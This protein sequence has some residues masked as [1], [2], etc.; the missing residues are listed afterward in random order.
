[1]VNARFYSLFITNMMIQ[2]CSIQRTL[3]VA[4]FEHMFSSFFVVCVCCAMT[5]AQNDM[6]RVRK[7][8][9]ITSHMLHSVSSVGDNNFCRGA[10]SGLLRALYQSITYIYRI[11]DLWNKVMNKKS[12]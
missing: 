3:S 8:F 12:C 6:H 7:P 1:M 4:F 5:R 10:L 2:P 9:P 11:H